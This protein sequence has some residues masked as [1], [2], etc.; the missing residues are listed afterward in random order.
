MKQAIVMCLLVSLLW[1]PSA[2]S[3]AQSSLTVPQDP[4]VVGYLNLHKRHPD[5]NSGPDE[6]DREYSSARGLQR[7]NQ[8]R[9]FLESFKQLTERSRGVIDPKELQAIGNTSREMQT[10]GFHNIPLVIEGTILK[11]EYQMNQ[12]NYQLAQLRRQ[13][14]LITQQELDRARAAYEEAS[15]NFQVFWDTKLPTD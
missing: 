12:L 15:R 4:S 8:L 3:G 5:G 13:R 2:F 7:L 11:Y 1:I 14:A 6:F 9:G 10:I